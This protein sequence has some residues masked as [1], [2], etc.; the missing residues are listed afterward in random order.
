MN[1]ETWDQLFRANVDVPVLT[2]QRLLDRL[3]PCASI[4]STGSLI[5]EQPHSMF[6]AYGVSKSAVHALAKNLVKFLA[7]RVSASMR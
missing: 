1:L 6:R 3:A 4:V 2:I 7:P 5:G